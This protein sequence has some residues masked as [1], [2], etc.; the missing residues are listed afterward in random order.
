MREGHEVIKIIG[1]NDEAIEK[2]DILRWL[3]ANPE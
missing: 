3:K 1:P 2:E